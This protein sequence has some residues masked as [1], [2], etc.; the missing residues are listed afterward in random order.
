[1]FFFSAGLLQLKMNGFIKVCFFEAYI[2]AERNERAS[3]ASERSVRSGFQVSLSC[4]EK[5][6]KKNEIRF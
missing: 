3:A 4:L 1:M 2:I 6:F 5:R